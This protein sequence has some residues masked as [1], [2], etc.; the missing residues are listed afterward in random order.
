MPYMAGNQLFES[1]MRSVLSFV[2]IEFS[3]SETIL[4]FRSVTLEF[5]HCFGFLS[6]IYSC[7]RKIREGLEM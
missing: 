6:F 2:T 7:L 5:L 1:H 3:Q 4:H